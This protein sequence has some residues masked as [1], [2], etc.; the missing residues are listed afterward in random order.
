MK[1]QLQHVAANLRPSFQRSCQ[2]TT[3]QKP[4]Q[5]ERKRHDFPERSRGTE[6][7][8]VSEP[9]YRHI[10]QFEVKEHNVHIIRHLHFTVRAHLKL[11]LCA[12][13]FKLAVFFLFPVRAEF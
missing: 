6:E 11:L 5:L 4:S 12:P 3:A 8:D 10:I 1:L 2:E 9:C 13:N 7:D